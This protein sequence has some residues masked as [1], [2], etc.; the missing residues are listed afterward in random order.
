MP[1]K[2]IAVDIFSSCLCVLILN[3]SWASSTYKGVRNLEFQE[4]G[5]IKE[6]TFIRCDTMAISVSGSRELQPVPGTG[7][8]RC[9]PRFSPGK[10]AATPLPRKVAVFLM[11]L[12]GILLSGL[13]VTAVILPL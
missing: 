12:Y 4:I 8:K 1:N 3:S 13:I 6:G 10:E 5:R 7:S 9:D 2:L 11:T